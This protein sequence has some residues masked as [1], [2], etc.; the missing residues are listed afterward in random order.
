MPKIAKWQ[1]NLPKIEQK[2]EKK[3]KKLQKPNFKKEY[4]SKSKPKYLVALVSTFFEK[5]SAPAN[6]EKKLKNVDSTFNSGKPKIIL[7]WH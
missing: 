2:L 3:S 7:F 1:Q 6:I 4:K 5:S